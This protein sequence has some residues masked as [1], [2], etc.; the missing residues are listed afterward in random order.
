M[1]EYGHYITPHQK[2]TPLLSNDPIKE[3]KAARRKVL[4]EV[5]PRRAENYKRF[6]EKAKLQASSKIDTIV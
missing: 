6:L 3:K 5:E 2:P 1:T 4:D